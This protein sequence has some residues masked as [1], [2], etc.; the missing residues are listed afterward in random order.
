MDR[1]KQHWTK[2]NTTERKKTRYSKLQNQATHS[3]SKTVDEPV[4]SKDVSLFVS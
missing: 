2:N 4:C 1:H 3:P